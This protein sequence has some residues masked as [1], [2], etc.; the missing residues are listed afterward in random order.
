MCEVVDLWLELL[1]EENE[2]FDALRD[3]LKGSWTRKGPV[4]IRVRQ[5]K[6]ILL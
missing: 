2:S 5:Q 4:R 3:V 1:L 6:V